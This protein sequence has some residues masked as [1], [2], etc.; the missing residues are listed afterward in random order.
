MFSI[1]VGIALLNYSRFLACLQ[2]IEKI[3]PN[4]DIERFFYKQ[5]TLTYIWKYV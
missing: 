2:I 5:N 3:G 1:T 4:L